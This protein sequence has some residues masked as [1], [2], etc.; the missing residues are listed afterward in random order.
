MRNNFYGIRKDRAGTFMNSRAKQQEVAQEVA[1]AVANSVIMGHDHANPFQ[2]DSGIEVDENR[3][4]FYAEV[5]EKE[6]LE[7]NKILR[8]LDI[9]MEYLKRRLDLS[10]QPPIRLFIHSPGGS[11]FS[12]LSIVDTL[13][14]CKSPIHTY[15][16]GHAASAATLVSVAGTKRFATKNSFMLIHQ[17]RMIWEG[18]HADFIDEIENQKHVTDTMKRIY[19]EKTKMSESELSSILKR[20]LHIPADECLRLGLIDEII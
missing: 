15:I 17:Q 12:A 2:K 4:Y 13:R 10:E 18:K 9:E 5:S 3:V 1:S 6:A 7:L 20:E 11:F 19:M 16:D 8:H 14:R